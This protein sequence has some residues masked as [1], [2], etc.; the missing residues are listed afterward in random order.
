MFYL[1]K[2]SYV[3]REAKAIFQA[4]FVRQCIAQLAGCGSRICEECLCGA[5]HEC[6]GE[7]D[8]LLRLCGLEGKTMRLM[9]RQAT[10]KMSYSCAALWCYRLTSKYKY[11]NLY[12]P[13]TCKKKPLLILKI[14][15][16]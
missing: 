12:H 8:G 13:T 6:H 9:F 11:Y 7:H 2:Q 4:D 3:Q 10:V 16:L 5:V 1:V 14:I 15:N